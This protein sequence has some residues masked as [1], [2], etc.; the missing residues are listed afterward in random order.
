MDLPADLRVVVRH[1]RR[2]RPR[3]GA[4]DRGAGRRAG[5]R[6][7]G[8]G[9]RH[10]PV[11][12]AVGGA[13]R[14][15]A[16]AG[17]RR[18]PAGL[19]PRGPGQLVPGSGHRAVQRGGHPRRALRAGQLPG[20][21]APAEAVDDADHLLR[22]PAAGRPG[23]A[24]LVGVAE[25]HAAQL[26]RPLDRRADPVLG[27]GEDRRGVHHPARHP[28]RGDVPGAG[29]G[30]PAGRRADRAV[31]AGGHRPAVD[32]RRG[33]PGRGGG[34]LPAAGLPALGARPA[35]RGPGEDRRLAGRDRGEPG[36]RPGAAGVHRRLRADRLRHRRD[37]GG[38]RRGH[39]RLGVRGG[40]R[41]ARRP[42]RAAPG[43]LGRRR[44]HRRGPDD[45]LVE[46]RDL[47]R[48]AGEARGDRGDDPLAGRAG[49]R[50]RRR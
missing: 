19:H 15:R 11:G 2:R 9:R 30:A 1:R 17:R 27:G 8:A 20:V 24:G 3:Q 21:P 35:G 6:H 16:A 13:V 40:L 42:H 29:A 37:H 49:E 32:R 34:G 10:Q 14:G 38:P 5:R 22:R 7:P 48:R 44:L 39:P 33:D 12:P 4:P 43:G 46:R 26:D 50:A 25:A 28:V 31:L 47:P 23:P 41:A 45:Q 18:P 36:Q